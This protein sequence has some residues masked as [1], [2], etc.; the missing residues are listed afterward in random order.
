MT[1]RLYYNAADARAKASDEWHEEW[2]SKSGLKARLW[3]DKAIR[4][5]LGAPLNVGPIKAW[6]QNTVKKV[7]ST[8]AFKIWLEQRRSWLIARGKLTADT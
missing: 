6:K 4:E 3:T 1:S 2:I 5:F 8:P 7:E